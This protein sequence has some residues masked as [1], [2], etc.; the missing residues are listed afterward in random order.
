MTKNQ[1]RAINEDRLKS[2]AKKL[3][4]NHSTPIML[5]GVG[6]DHRSGQLH[7]VTLEDKEFDRKTLAAFAAWA[8]EQLLDKN[9]AQG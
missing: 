8:T 1:C 5:V 7:L 3:T 2:W 4:D 9:D 6:H